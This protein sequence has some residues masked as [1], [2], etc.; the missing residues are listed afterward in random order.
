MLTQIC[1]YLRNWFERTKLFGEI[2][3]EGGVISIGGNVISLLDGQYF[4][5]IGSVLNDGVH[6]YPAS[7][8]QDET[9]NGAIWCMAVPPV[10]VELAEDIQKWT[11]DNEA[12]ISSPYS[13]ESFGGYSYSLKSGSDSSGSQGGVTWESQFASRLSPWRKI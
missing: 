5:I 13:S 1:Q 11:E 12:A 7:D 6:A 4:R 2:V 3:I 10:I 8:L 9:F